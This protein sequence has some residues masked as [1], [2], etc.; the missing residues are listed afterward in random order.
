[1][2]IMVAVA[3]AFLLVLP[4]LPQ[5][6]RR[7]AE[8]LDV[9]LVEVPV[10]VVDRDGNP[11]RDLK[12]EQFEIWDGGVKR[13]LTYF[14]VLD[15][16]KAAGSTVDINTPVAVARSFMLLF[17]ETRAT[18]ASL[19]RAREAASVF[20]DKQ[21]FERDR[22]AVGVMSVQSGFRLLTGFTTD[23]E[24]VKKAVMTLGEPSQF[25]IRDPLLLAANDFDLR[26]DESLGNR[27]PEGADAARLAAVDQFR[28]LARAQRNSAREQQKH[29][30]M[31]TLDDLS[32]LGRVLDRVHGR[33]QVILLSEGFDAKSVQGRDS[34]STLE[35][36][37]EQ[38]FIERG[39]GYLV[40]NDNRYGSAEANNALRRMIEALR[41]SDVI[42]H[43]IDIKGLR[44][45]VDAATGHNPSST[46]SLSLLTRDTG[47][48]VFKHSN[49]LSASFARMLKQQDV[50][51]LLAFKAPS[52][53]PGKFHDLKVKVNGLPIGS[54]VSHRAGYYEDT[55]ATS[56]I[57]RTLSAG[58]ILMNSIP[59]EDIKVRAFAAA[60][61]RKGNAAQAPVVLEIDGKS[62]VAESIDPTVPTDFYIYAFDDQDQIRDFAY[63][64][65]S[66]D[67]RK[68]R[69]KL[70]AK[71]VKFYSTLLLPPGDFSL[72]VL[73]RTAAGRSGFTTARVH[74]PA[75]GEPLAS[76]VLFDESTWWVMVKA[77]DR[78]S[79]PNYPF[80]AGDT[81]FVPAARA[82]LAGGMPY[83]VAVMT[84]NLPPEQVSVD[85]ALEGG[86]GKQPL[87]LSF[88][89]R[90]P[91]D[92][93]G[94]VKLMY[95]VKPPRLETGEYQ[96]VMNVRT[97]SGAQTRSVS[98]PVEVR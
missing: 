86:R 37:E 10:T 17:D 96:L 47:G 22:V 24:L 35:A 56:D 28:E 50:T 33:K 31:R 42:M 58:E 16:S 92:S 76:P 87:A 81:T 54:R 43:A 68:L 8:T 67:L 34:L 41:R 2:R 30:I 72:R 73:V 94:G 97:A 45:D 6:Q 23:R 61:P 53:T 79:K 5:P 11:L 63:Q 52:T 57:D 1:M 83:T 66:F 89:G 95:E 46:E 55:A 51:Y 26:A 32:A 85:A 82:Q 84:Y 62:L 7:T 78:P 91:P 4:A 74:V 80:M 44:S 25:Q 98:M 18:P 48:T 36:R 19:S 21:L 60:Y 29:D 49:D 14:D 71:G 65:V 69:T 75:E 70:E 20:V 39:A 15:L 90:T 3:T 59:V 40:D 13:D 64:R 88:L 12:R 38:I 93:D 9:V 77:Q 27:G